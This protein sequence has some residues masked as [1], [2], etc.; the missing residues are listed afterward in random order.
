MLHAAAERVHKKRETRHTAQN[1]VVGDWAR[2][3]REM[4]KPRIEDPMQEL[5][6]RGCTPITRRLGLAVVLVAIYAMPALSLDFSNDRFVYR[7]DF[8]GEISF[9]TTVEVDLIAAGGLRGGSDSDLLGP[10]RSSRAR[11]CMRAHPPRPHLRKPCFSFRA[12][13][14]LLRLAYAVNSRACRCLLR[15]EGSFS[16]SAVSTYSPA[17][18]TFRRLRCG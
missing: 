17:E 6:L 9:P 7:E 18:R 1:C 3:A 4:G 16:S 15:H 2:R 11:A 8:N 14:I 12:R 10:P 5:N 13:S